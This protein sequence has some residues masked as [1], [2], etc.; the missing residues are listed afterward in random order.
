MQR[1]PRC[2]PRQKTLLGIQGPKQLW[3][4]IDHAADLVVQLLENPH[5]FVEQLVVTRRAF[6]KQ[7]RQKAN[8]TL[9]G[10]AEFHSRSAVNELTANWHLAD[11]RTVRR[12]CFDIAGHWRREACVIKNNFR[13]GKGHAGQ[14]GHNQ[15]L[16][17][18][19]QRTRGTAA[20]S[21]SAS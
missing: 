13:I 18:P 7:L 1:D 15:L 20:S 2:Q 6:L 9:L 10:D 19:L 11:D 12:V 8:P 21:G 5:K 4:A 14:I 16:G 3:H 17:A